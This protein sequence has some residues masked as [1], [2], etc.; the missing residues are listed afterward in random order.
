MTVHQ[1]RLRSTLSPVPLIAALVLAL[2]CFA[3]LVPRQAH[4]LIVGAEANGEL[5]NSDR[6][7]ALQA[8]ALDKMQAQG[9]QLV[10][11]NVGW[12][13][14]AAGC[15]T[16]SLQAQKNPDNGCY[17]WAVLDSLVQLAGQRNIKVLMSSMRAPKWLHKSSN[18]YYLGKTSSQFNRTVSYY[19]AFVQ[20]AGARYKPGSAHGT[21]PYWTIRN[22][23]N[24]N[25]FFQPKPDAARYALMYA[26]AAVALKSVNP[27]A[28]VAPGPTGPKS[29]IKPVPFIKTF[30][31]SVVKFLPKGNP[32]RYINAW[33]H[34]PYPGSQGP[35]GYAS[36]KYKGTSFGRQGGPDAL[37][38][39][40]TPK[41]IKLLDSKPI[42]RGVA[43]WGTEFGWET[44]PE[45]RP[46][47]FVS[48]ALQA[49]YIAEAF[50]FL[51][52]QK[53]VTIAVQYGLTD[54]TNNVDWQS[55]TYTAAG[56][57]KPS[58]YMYQRPI[59]ASSGFGKRGTMVHVYGRS[60]IAP[61]TSHLVYR[62]TS[63]LASTA[64][65]ALTLSFC[66]A[67]VKNAVQAGDGSWSANVKLTAAETYFAVYDGVQTV[68]TGGS[69]YGYYRRVLAN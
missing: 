18:E 6:T 21:I 9:T 61:A 17:N 46:T 13:E 59:A 1:I 47:L 33:A 31:T 56:V 34:N 37:G 12:T 3:L 32:K 25:T 41:L 57:P 68:A 27:A 69:G 10:R 62:T 51:T 11:V 43:V 49:Q 35:A 24:S 52:R 53:R 50:D 7:P 20:A 55:G 42:T 5:V 63:P 39:A 16:T 29:T 28:L 48:H 66:W 26:R 54:N 44:P 19:A 67:Y 2:C 36:G 40:E 14:I 4:A 60:N 15:G 65:T 64:C 38:M 58:F 30:Q 45:Y 22:E 23:P 8:A